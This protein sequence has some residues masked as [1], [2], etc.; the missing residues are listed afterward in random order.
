MIQ[1]ETALCGYCEELPEKGRAAAAHVNRCPLCKAELG[2]TGAGRRFRIGGDVPAPRGR[3]L[4]AAALAIAG[5]GMVLAVVTWME[6]VL[7]AGLTDPLGRCASAMK[8]LV[9]LES[10]TSAL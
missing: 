7:S 1:T 4:M 6:V 3:R 10:A 8:S 2:V 9:V 5:G